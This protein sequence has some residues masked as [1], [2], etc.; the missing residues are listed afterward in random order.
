M[1]LCGGSFISMICD[2]CVCVCFYLWIIYGG[3]TYCF[4]K[5]ITAHLLKLFELFKEGC[6][7]WMN[8]V[9]LMGD[10]RYAWLIMWACGGLYVVNGGWGIYG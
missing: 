10:A 4:L 1:E 2:G 6:R 5:M 8:Y 7:R 9:G 3:S